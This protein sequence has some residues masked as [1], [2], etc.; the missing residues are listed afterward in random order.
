MV[1]RSSDSISNS[2][3][4]VVHSFLTLSGT[5]ITTV[6]LHNYPQ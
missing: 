2:P 1:L 4:G 3:G 6:K 5:I